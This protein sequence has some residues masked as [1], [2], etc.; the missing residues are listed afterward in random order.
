MP[1]PKAPN[2]ALPKSLPPKTA[3]RLTSA[4]RKKFAPARKGRAAILRYQILEQLVLDACTKAQNY[5]VAP[6]DR[7]IIR[8]RMDSEFLRDLPRH[9]QD[10]KGVANFIRQYGGRVGPAL[11]QMHRVEGIQIV[12]SKKTSLDAAWFALLSAYEA[13]LEPHYLPAKSGPFVH[14]F[15]DGPLDFGEA[16]DRRR[17]PRIKAAQTGLLFELALYFKRF[18]SGVDGDL[19]GYMQTGEPLPLSGNPCWKLCGQ[20]LAE[21]FGGEVRPDGLGRRLRKLRAKHPKL[22]FVG[23]PEPATEL[24]S[25]E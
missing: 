16:I 18:T 10:V 5:E 1:T 21:V 14:R 3:R 22:T 12:F 4:M 13:A 6:A 17:G 20:A 25:K 9:R 23:W 11:K 7:N 19:L 8:R 24:K 15:Q 2:L